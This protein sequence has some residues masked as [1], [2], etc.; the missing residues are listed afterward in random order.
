MNNKH[1]DVWLKAAVIG[2]IWAGFEIIFGSFFHSLRLPFAGTFLTFTS[3]VLLIAFSYKWHDKNLFLKAGIIA[4]L[5]RSLMPTS[6]ILG[7]LIGILIEAILFQLALN[8][9]GRNFFAFATA[10][11]LAMFSAIVHKIISIIL[12]YG[13]DIVKILENLYYV[14]L[15]IT[16]VNL[17]VEKLLLLVGA[18]YVLLGLTAATIGQ[19]AG[20][21]LSNETISKDV[22]IDNLVIKNDLFDIAHFKYQSKYIWFHLILLVLFLTGLEFLSLQIL[23]IPILIYLFLIYKRYGKSLRRL[24]KPLFWLQLV[25][26]VLLAVL[27]WQ[28]KTEGLIIG[29]KMI[30]RAILVVSVFTAISV[31]LKNPLIKALLYKKG[32]SQ[33]YTT[34][35][36]A[37]SALPFILKH[38]SDDK[39]SLFKPLKILKKAIGLSDLLLQTFTKQIEQ[40]NKIFIISGETRSGKTTF[41]KESI[42]SIK[43]NN[44]AIKIGGIIAHGIDVNGERFGFHIEN[45]A[46]GK[47]QFL[48]SIETDEPENAIKIGRFYFS[49]Q[50]LEFGI[51]SI[52]QDI[53]QLDILVIDEIGY[54]ELQGKGWFEAIE[55]AMSQP[56]LTMVFVVRKRIL[57]QVL[58]LWQ[59]KHIIVMDIKNNKPADLIKALQNN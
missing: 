55:K 13:F 26:I 40:K 45:I 41:I 17:P 28:D 14:L 52:L 51:Q 36:L 58:K 43:N 12:I 47:K 15:R 6:V 7:P 9:F 11:I 1:Q 42:I 10:G 33:L 48:C 29:V 38:I 18:G 22:N 16:H 54:L 44:P 5:I 27:L 53:N 19:I 2:S 31:E 8:L 35:G 34:L 24:G 21:N 46:S 32:Y 23:I 3:I 57:E 49:P 4:A 59:N 56:N 25:I 39:K 30:L 50:G 37:T 20:K